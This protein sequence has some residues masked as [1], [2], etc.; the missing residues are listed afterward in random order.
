LFECAAFKVYLPCTLNA[1]DLNTGKENNTGSEHLLKKYLHRITELQFLQ[2]RR[3]ITFFFFV[4]ISASFWFV[5]S[6][7]EVYEDEVSYPVRYI[8]F[9]ENKV[10]AGAVPDVLQLRV[11]AKGFSLLRCKLNMNLIPL[12]FDIS[13]LV[14]NSMGADTFYVVTETARE[15]LSAE[16]SQL[17]I[18]DITPDTLFFR[19]TDVF[20]KTIP[21]R[22]VLALHDE[23]FQKQFMQNGHII[24]SPDSIVV[25]GPGNIIR[26]IEYASTEPIS[27]TNL[28]D[29]VELHCKLILIDRVTFSH[30]NVQVIIPVDRF[31][32]VDESI[33]VQPVNVP[34]SLNMIAIPGQ[35]TM[36]YNICLSNYNRLEKNPPVPRIDF[37]AIGEKQM[38][39]LVVFLT[40]TPGII[41]N[42]RFNPKETEFLVTR[43]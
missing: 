26:D 9:P 14:L 35:V 17:S 21:V 24:V 1:V 41:S 39:R 16:L 22:A 42:V 34:D 13:S 19:F 3:L 23:F 20:E 27:R 43:K 7:G 15:S 36:T 6:L 28:S 12:K 8:N 31:T 37:N 11:R 25:S 38:T 10:L 30:Q 32:E 2:Q 33:A 5:R 29:T 4:L 40:D 18:L